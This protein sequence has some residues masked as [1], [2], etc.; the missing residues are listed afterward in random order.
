MTRAFFDL[1]TLRRAVALK[2]AD[3]GAA[4]SETQG[5]DALVG[6]GKP[7]LDTLKNDPWGHR[8]AYHVGASGPVVYSVGPNGID[9]HGGG[10]DVTTADKSYRCEDFARECGVTR[11]DLEF[12]GPLAVAAAALA[13]L[14]WRGIAA[15]RR[16]ARR[17]PAA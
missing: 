13:L 1:D 11:E 14:L 10:D 17:P 6:G 5:L 7:Q 4:P 2:A 16:L 15:G 8:Y 3:D 12:G 9:E